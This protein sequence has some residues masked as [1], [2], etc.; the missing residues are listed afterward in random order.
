MNPDFVTLGRA[1]GFHSERVEKTADFAD[2]FQ[3]ARDSASGAVLELVIDPD[4][5][6]PN[7]ILSD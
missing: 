4:D 7:V 2:A 6:A 3:R 1:Y 5:I